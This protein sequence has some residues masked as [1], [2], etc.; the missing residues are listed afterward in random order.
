MVLTH[1]RFCTKCIGLPTSEISQYIAGCE[2]FESTCTSAYRRKIFSYSTTSD[3]AVTVTHF[4]SQ[5]FPTAH[6]TYVTSS[7]LCILRSLIMLV[8]S[9]HSA[10]EQFLDQICPEQQYLLTKNVPL[11]LT[12]FDLH[13]V[14]PAI[15][16][17]FQASCEVHCLEFG[18][19][20]LQFCCSHCKFSGSWVESINPCIIT[21][22]YL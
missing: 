1:V 14:I 21:C 15:P 4:R 8:S 5:T 12:S 19:Y 16:T 10:I 9:T 7:H 13:V 18:Q 3:D 6:E 2:N 20:I 22:D 17:L 11:K